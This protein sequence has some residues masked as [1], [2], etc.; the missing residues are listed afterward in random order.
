MGLTIHYEIEVEAGVDAAE[1][2]RL[3]T[4]GRTLAGRMWQ[5]FRKVGGVLNRTRG[6]STG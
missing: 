5:R 4:E 1:A 3:V 6:S 2:R